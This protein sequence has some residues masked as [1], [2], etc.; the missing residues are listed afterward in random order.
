MGNVYPQH[1]ELRL[2]DRLLRLSGGAVF[3]VF[4][5]F[6]ADKFGIHH[7][8]LGEFMESIMSSGTGENGIARYAKVSICRLFMRFTYGVNR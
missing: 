2:M 6:L 7:S 4:M 3:P 8:L 5:G 1:P